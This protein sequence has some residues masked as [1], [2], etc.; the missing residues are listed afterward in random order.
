MR[1]HFFAAHKIRPSD[2]GSRERG[3][4]HLKIMIEQM[5]REGRSERAIDRA[6]REAAAN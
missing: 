4:T 3:E 1:R 2:N 6:V 5:V